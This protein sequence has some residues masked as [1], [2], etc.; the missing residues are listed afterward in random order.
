MQKK[1]YGIIGLGTFG[2]CIAKELTR[3]GGQ[4]LAIDKDEEIVNEV[5][6]FVTQA[7]IADATEEKTLRE[8]AITDC[9]TVIVAIGESMETSIMITLLLKD[10]GVRNIIVKSVSDIHSRIISKIGVDRIVFPEQEY[11]KKTAEKLISPNIL[12]EIELSPEYN[13]IELVAPKEFTGKTIKDSNIRPNFRVNI[14][15]IKRLSP[16]ITDDGQSDTKEEINIAPGADDEIQENDILLLV[17]R[18]TDLQR[19][20]AVGK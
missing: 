8:L 18:E 4:V 9:D 7:V 6:Q 5:S 15:A 20:K 16:V 17:G 3:L 19:L 14:I 13:I 1:Q 12:D 2:A 10:L 11:A